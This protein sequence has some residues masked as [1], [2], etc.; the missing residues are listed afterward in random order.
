MI[1]GTIYTIEAISNWIQQQL[2]EVYSSEIGYTNTIEVRD[3]TSAM[4]PATI[5]V[6]RVNFSPVPPV[7]APIFASEVWW[8][9]V[10]VV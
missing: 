5:I 4:V 9:V 6:A 1:L 3:A 7:S 10:V 8:F 2:A